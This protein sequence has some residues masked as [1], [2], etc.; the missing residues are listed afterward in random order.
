MWYQRSYHL[1]KAGMTTSHFQ[2]RRKKPQGTSDLLKAPVSWW[3]SPHPVLKGHGCSVSRTC[4]ARTDP[5]P[6]ASPATP[7]LCALSRHSHIHLL[8]KQRFH[9]LGTTLKCFVCNF[10]FNCPRIP[11]NSYY[12]LH[13]IESQ[14]AFWQS[15]DLNANL[16]QFSNQ[17]L[18]LLSM[19]TR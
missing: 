14:P 7:W 11:C 5:G 2:T 1:N 13:F 10:S 3:H 9:V 4:P 12:Y 18:P 6:H 8:H 19:S 15:Q 17:T 16:S